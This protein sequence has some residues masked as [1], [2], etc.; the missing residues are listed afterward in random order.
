[1][2]SEVRDEVGKIKIPHRRV[3][4][5]T[6]GRRAWVSR[7]RGEGSGGVRRGRGMVWGGAVTNPAQP[8]PTIK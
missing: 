6:P 2:Q 8:G 1:M 3:C 5:D 7:G 4:F